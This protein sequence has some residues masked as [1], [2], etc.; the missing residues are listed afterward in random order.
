MIEMKDRTEA[1]I[2]WKIK[3]CFSS[4]FSTLFQARR[5]GGEFQN[6]LLI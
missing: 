5:G 4:E 6:V 2:K 3:V 1:T